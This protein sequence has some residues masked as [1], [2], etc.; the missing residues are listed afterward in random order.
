[1]IFAH[2][3]MENII[4]LS[5]EYIATLVIENR[6]F[7]RKLLWDIKQQIEGEDGDTV[8]SEGLQQYALSK[9]AELIDGYLTFSV[10]S[11][12][13]QN[14]IIAALEKKAVNEEFFLQSSEL[15]QNIEKYLYALTEDFTAELEFA[16]ISIATLLKAAN[17]QIAETN[18]SPL[19]IYL[20]Y[21]ELIRELDC[22]K[23][24]I[25]VNLR[26]FYSDEEL[27][28]FLQTVMAKEYKVLLIDSTSNDIIPF[29]KR[30]TI[31]TDL[32]EF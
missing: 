24:F 10:N 30:L 27:L 2:P 6:Y 28:P 21:M 12:K 17:I 9:R 26:S 20:D 32:C 11:K 19:E 8:L 25:F 16:S 15:L 14:K 3:E 18:S 13:T 29:E 4:E 1:M 31:D 7:F 23:L 22:D 5:P